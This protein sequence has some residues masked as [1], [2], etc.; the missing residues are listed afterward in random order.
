LNSNTGDIFDRDK[1]A[2]S[3]PFEPILDLDRDCMFNNEGY[4][5]SATFSPTLDLEVD[6]VDGMYGLEAS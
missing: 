4:S 6:G 1:F 2:S 5:Y 3:Q